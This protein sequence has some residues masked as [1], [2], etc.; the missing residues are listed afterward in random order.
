MN[1]LPQG[2]SARS[3]ASFLPGEGCRLG[4][5]Y[6]YVF[7]SV[8]LVA[9]TPS[10]AVAQ[11][12]RSFVL[13]KDQVV[14]PSGSSATG[15][16]A[17]R[18]STDET[19][20]AF[21]IQHDLT[22]ATV[23]TVR[24][25]DWG[26]NGPVVFTFAS[27]ASPIYDNWLLSANDVSELKA[28]RLYVQI[29]TA[30]QPA[31]ALRG[32]ID[33]N[34]DP[35][36]G[37]VIISEIMYDPRSSEDP[38]SPAEWIELFNRTYTDINIGGWFFQ[39]EDVELAAPCTLLRSSTIPDFVLRSG[40]VVVI[41]P[42]G[43]PGALPTVNDFRMAW[44]LNEGRSTP[45]QPADKRIRSLSQR[46]AIAPAIRTDQSRERARGSPCTWQRQGMSPAGPD[47]Q[48]PLARADN[49]LALVVAPGSLF[50]QQG[51][52]VAVDLVVRN[53]T[54][55]INGV[56]A[57]MSYDDNVMT[58]LEIDPGQAGAQPWTELA[59]ADDDGALLYALILLGGSTD[60]DGMAAT[61][62]FRAIAP[63]VTSI[64]FLPDYPPEFPGL[65]TKLTDAVTADAIPPS[66]IES[67][68]VS[69]GA[70]DD[71]LWCTSDGFDGVQCTFTVIPGACLIN[72]VCNSDQDPNPDNVCQVCD[73]TATQLGWSPGPDGVACDDLDFATSDDVCV[74]GKCA[75]SPSAVV[76]LQLNDDGETGGALAG[77]SLANDPVNDLN[78]NNDL[79]LD[80]PQW[81]PCNPLGAARPDNEIVVLT[82]GVTIYDTVN[83]DDDDPLTSP[84]PYR[85]GQSSITIVPA[86]FPGKNDLTNYTSS[87]NDDGGNWWTHTHGDGAGGFQQIN[88]SGVYSGLDI[89]SPGYLYGVTPGN[90]QPK[91]ILQKIPTTPGATVDFNLQ[92][93]DQSRP[94]FGL[95]LF[96]VKSIP[97]HGTLIDVAS[98]HVITAQDVQGSGYLIPRPPFN[99]LCYVQD[100]TGYTDSF[101]FTTSDGLLESYS[102]AV[103]FYIQRGPLV[104]T[105]IMYDPSS[106][107][108]DHAALTE[109]VELYNVSG[110]PVNLYEWYLTDDVGRAGA[111][112][113]YILG[114][115][116]A[117][118]LIPA[119]GD[120][121]EF[122]DAWSAAS[123]QATTNGQTGESGEIA[124]DELGSRPGDDLVLARPYP[125][126]M[127]V[128]DVVLYRNG[129]DDPTWPAM[130]PNGLSIYCLPGMYDVALNDEASSWAASIAGIHGAY[131]SSVTPLYDS[132][133]TGSPAYLHG[134]T[135][136]PCTNDSPTSDGNG[137]GAVD[138]VDFAHF[139]MCLHGPS[140][141]L[142]LNCGCFD[143]EPDGD[144][145]LADFAVEQSTLA[146]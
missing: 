75:G 6:A 71:D 39:D 106:A 136:G 64:G 36:P 112:P 74:A 129:I 123:V 103:T 80:S 14:P 140:T 63:A 89:G 13:T 59:Q 121:S 108:D 2:Q 37:D 11:L 76:V 99:L 62:R 100:G 110:Q 40:H 78:P 7:C 20:L 10:P 15:R 72:G 21:I 118:T 79:P 25:A 42:D 120:G 23:A 54:R 33:L 88:S 130:D 132:V 24:N 104:I 16:G 26:Q 138:L 58:L 3:A 93:S 53:L 28:G 57:L 61:L 91:A 119:A 141:P 83:Y 82:D 9:A 12:V 114:A 50:V 94:L 17:S 77:F 67:G 81:A 1:R 52:E 107:D 60:A 115:G 137:D 30:G 46:K 127:Q 55:P 32:Q 69:I 56:Q 38:P 135:Q 5:I 105:E 84:W 95:L 111:L 47:E 116:S 41:I 49:E 90:Q 35:K 51:D 142:P 8:A 113:E 27:P 117:V 96:I 66:R 144:V 133:D 19:E 68:D 29:D 43:T 124:G 125:E 122:D 44:G 65:A 126:Q 131:E 146:H 92:G 102:A 70:C 4:P 87:G 143:A 134:I 45:R 109:W 31:G 101:A 22:D 85:S 128:S 86:D 34:P 145:D 98:N 18:L 48:H 139:A 97:Q 73:S